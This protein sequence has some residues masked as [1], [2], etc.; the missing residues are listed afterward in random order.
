ME[1][2]V[3]LGSGQAIDFRGCL[4]NRCTSCGH[5]SNGGIAEGVMTLFKDERVKA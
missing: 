2:Q 4:R 1:F 3:T 5:R